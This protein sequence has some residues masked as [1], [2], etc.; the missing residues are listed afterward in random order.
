M[1]VEV[2]VGVVE[3]LPGAGVPAKPQSRR[4]QSVV[5]DHTR[6]AHPQFLG[7]EGRMAE[8][9]DRVGPDPGPLRRTGNWALVKQPS[10]LTSPVELRSRGRVERVRS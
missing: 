1:A 3:L 8:S 7:V 10:L 5:P 2:E 9:C 6:C 4:R